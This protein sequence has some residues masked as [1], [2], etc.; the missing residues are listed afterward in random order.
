MVERVVTASNIIRGYQPVECG[1]YMYAMPI[2]SD[3]EN[4]TNTT[5]RL[6][7]TNRTDGILSKHFHV[8]GVWSVRTLCTVCHALASSGADLICARICTH[9]SHQL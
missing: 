2:A 4:A 9:N 6:V 1:M 7:I 3:G 5:K 8:L